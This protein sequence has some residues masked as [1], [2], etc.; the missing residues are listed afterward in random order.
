MHDYLQHSGRK[1]FPEQLKL[2]G[3][4]S[5]KK[6]LLYAPPLAVV[7][8]PR[9]KAHRGLPQHRLRASQDLRV[10]REGGGGQPAQGRC[11]QG[12]G[13]ARRSVQASRQQCLRQIHRSGGAAEQNRVHPR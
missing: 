9:S 4:F 2:L 3:V 10:V 6:I 8:R 7:P 12:Q 11:R 5:A 1:R 13:P